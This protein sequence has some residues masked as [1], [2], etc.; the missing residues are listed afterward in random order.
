MTSVTSRFQGA[1]S[2]GSS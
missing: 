1:F 2:I